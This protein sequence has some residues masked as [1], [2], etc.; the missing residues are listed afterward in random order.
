MHNKPLFWEQ[1]LFLQAQHFQMEQR[2]HMHTRAY[3]SA[4]LNPYLHG[5]GRLEINEGALDG[6]RFEIT[7]LSLLTKDGDWIS[8]PDNATLAPRPFREAWKNPE[9]PLPVFL[10]LAPFRETGDNVLQTDTPETAP[11]SYRY[12]TPLTPDLAADLHGKGPPADVRAL[13]YRMQLCLGD[14]MRNTLTRIPVA[15]LIRDGERARLD[16]DFLPPLIDIHAF[17]TLASLLRDVRDVL[18]SRARQLEEFKMVGGEIAKSSQTT[19]LYGITLFSILGVISRNVP[20]LEQWLA[21]PR[22]H[23]WPV[24]IALSRLVGELSAFSASLSPLG[25]TPQGERAVPPYDHEQPY[26]CFQAACGVITRLVDALVVGPDFS[27]TLEARGDFWK[28]SIPQS[29]RNNSY[30]YWLLMRSQTDP[31]LA[32]KTAAF[33]KLAPSPALPNIVARALPGIRLIHAEAPPVGLP[34]R[35]D[36]AYF[37]IDQSDPLWEETLQHGEVAF[38]L[39]DAPPDLW[40]QL[41]VIRE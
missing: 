11:D 34:R 30:A 25:E 33:G 39:P 32:Q 5:F 10:G 8:F 38:F 28:T 19:N 40:A 21:A 6:D 26:P 14:E 35:K 12:T 9:V 15:R 16:H 36:T 41:T 13:R 3:S 31:R 17:G 24:F 1:G 4:F 2:L 23:P 18:L 7:A 20:E 37:M 27:L 29:A 22:T